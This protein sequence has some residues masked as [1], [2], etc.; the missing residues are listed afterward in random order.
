MA[1]PDTVCLL[2]LL[3]GITCR[4]AGSHAHSGPFQDLVIKVAKEQQAA[5]AAPCTSS[6]LDGEAS[7]DTEAGPPAITVEG[8]SGPPDT[9][10][11][12]TA[13][14]VALAGPTVVPSLGPAAGTASSSCPPGEPSMELPVADRVDKAVNT[15]EKDV[16]SKLW[17]HRCGM[18]GLG[19]GA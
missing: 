17:K 15:L 10:T 4:W 14:D 12:A 19:K 9:T 7:A 3:P 8:V 16:Q 6:A 2:L 1:H 18:L 11:A 5:A 13:A